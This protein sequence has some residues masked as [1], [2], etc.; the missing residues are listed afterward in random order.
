MAAAGLFSVDTFMSKLDGKGSLARR[1][2]FFVEITPPGSLQSNYTAGSIEFLVKTATFPGRT[3]GTA[4][5]RHAGKYSLEVPYEVTEDMVTLGF[6]GTND[7]S[8]R[9]FWYNWLEHIQSIKKYNMT[10]Y[11]NFIGTVTIKTYKEHSDPSNDP[12]SHIVKLMEA[13]P[14]A[15][16]AIELGWENAEEVDFTVDIGYS[17]WETNA[18]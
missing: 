17:Y 4:N 10:Y 11:K 8:A 9:K 7:L 12:P 1:N 2:K 16:S 14:K 3:F 6:V 13:W 5:Y 18:N 15:M